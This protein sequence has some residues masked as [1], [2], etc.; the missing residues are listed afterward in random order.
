MK[1]YTRRQASSVILVV[2]ANVDLKPWL[3]E[4]SRNMCDEFEACLLHEKISYDVLPE[5]AKKM[6][7]EAYLLGWKHAK[8]KSSKWKDR[9]YFDTRLIDQ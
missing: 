4:F 6:R 1:L 9:D 8:A 3:I 2:E 5:I 7:Q